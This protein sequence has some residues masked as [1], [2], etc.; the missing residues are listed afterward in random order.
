[1]FAVDTDVDAGFR[2][3]SPWSG[4]VHDNGR[5]A[6]AIRRLEQ[7]PKLPASSLGTCGYSEKI[8]GNRL[9]AFRP[10]RLG[11]FLHPWT[12]A[13]RVPAGKLPL[14]N[15]IRIKL[16]TAFEPIIHARSE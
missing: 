10:D 13:K 5:T 12:A 11:F 8:R 16:L 2:R 1:L 6:N 4:V 15:T 7:V 3:S 14:G 9:S